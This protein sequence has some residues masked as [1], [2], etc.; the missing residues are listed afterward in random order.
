MWEMESLA[1]VEKFLNKCMA[2]KEWM[3]KFYPE[4]AALMVPGTHSLNV[5][6]PVP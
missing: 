4:F 6:T 3:T 1:D 5:W 2:D